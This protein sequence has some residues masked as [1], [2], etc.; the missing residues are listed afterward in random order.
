MV[1]GPEAMLK[2]TGSPDEA[3]ALTMNGGSPS[4]LLVRAP[5]VM[6]WMAAATVNERSTVGAAP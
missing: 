4:R 5:K 6:V 3:V 2:V 1:A